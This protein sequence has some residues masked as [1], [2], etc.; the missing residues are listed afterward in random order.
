MAA[1]VGQGE[2][3]VEHLDDAGLRAD[4]AA[5]ADLATALGVERRAVEEDLE[6][7]LAALARCRD[8][9]QHAGLGDVVGVADERRRAE[10]LDDLA[11]GVD[12]GV[13]AALLPGRLRPAALLAHLGLEARHVDGHVALAGDLLRQLEREAVRVVEHERGRAGELADAA[14]ELALEDR[15]AV[16]QRLAEALLLLAEHADDE[17]ALAGDVRVGVAHHRHGDIG[18]RRHDQLL[19]AEQVGVAHGTADDAPQHEPAGLV[20]REHAVG[21]EHRRRP[22]MLGED[23]HRE[24]VAVVVVA[25][26]VRAP[27]QRAGLRDERRHQ[28]GLPDRVDA[29][30][31]AEDP[32]EPG[33]GVDLRLR[34]RRPRAVR[35]LVVLHE[36]EVPELHEPVAVGVVERPAVR[37]ELRAAV[38][39]QL[40]AR[41][42]GAGVA[43][44]PE[45]VLVAEALDALHRDADDLV[46]DLLGLVVALVDG[47]PDA[48]GVEAPDLGDEL[49]AVGDRQ[50]LEVVP[51]AEVAEHLEEDEVALGPPDV[52]EVVVLA[53]GAHALLRAHRTGERRRLV[54][55]EVRL[56]RHHPGDVEEHRR[57]VRDEARR[58]DRCVLAPCEEVDE[59]LAELVGGA[60]RRGHRSWRAYL[61][62]GTREPGPPANSVSVRW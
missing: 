43:H 31:Q 45:V 8:D 62:P 60:R 9:R 33:A 7:V 4:R 50:L 22:G 27:G 16:A 18:E 44:L 57:V 49:P 61:G 15:E 2:R 37:S 5:V 47:D 21:H 24:A 55:H 36:H 11:V 30:Q 38:V 40:A 52:V 35:R 39:V 34:Q 29:L 54:A 25:G 20:A 41:S 28:V 51:E 53:A 26:P 23:P 56:E 32:L 19:R 42:A 46:P 48:L 3:R 58:G 59:R 14:G 1:Q 12:V 10:L 6:E 17:V 13:V